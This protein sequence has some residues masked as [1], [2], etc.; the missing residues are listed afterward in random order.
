MC[1]IGGAGGNRTNG[2]LDQYWYL[3]KCWL[4]AVIQ[5]LNTHRD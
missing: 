5:H 1:F 2:T 3:E 4:K